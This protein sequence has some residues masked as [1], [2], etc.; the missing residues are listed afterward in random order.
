MSFQKMKAASTAIYIPILCWQHNDERDFFLKWHSWIPHFFHKHY[1]RGKEKKRKK[2]KE[3]EKQKHIIEQ[4]NWIMHASSF[5]YTTVIFAF[6]TNKVNFFWQKHPG[7]VPGTIL[8]TLTYRIWIMQSR[9]VNNSQL[10][11]GSSCAQI[12]NHIP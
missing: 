1:Y 12:F 3:R 6:S 5:P 2:K 4:T 9:D 8:W 7:K 10:T 11:F